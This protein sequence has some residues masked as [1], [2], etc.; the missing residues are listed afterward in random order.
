MSQREIVGKYHR[1][2]RVKMAKKSIIK[3]NRAHTVREGLY[4]VMKSFMQ[5]RK[6]CKHSRRPQCHQEVSN[7]KSSDFARISKMSGKSPTVRKSFKYTRKSL[8]R[9]GHSSKMTGSVTKREEG[10]KIH[11]ETRLEEYEEE[12]LNLSVRGI[13]IQQSVSR[14]MLI[15]RF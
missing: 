3:E 5:I 4:Q 12:L 6:S 14:Q 10:S 11:H 2:S 13:H 1:I 8:I 15:I 9:S 7:R